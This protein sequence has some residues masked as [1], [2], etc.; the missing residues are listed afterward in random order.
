MLE[1]LDSILAHE[2][3]PKILVVGDVILDEYVTG[4]VGRISPEA[5]VPVLESTTVVKSPGGAANVAANLAALGCDVLLVG[6]VG[7]DAPGDALT[8]LL[9][10][11]GISTAGLVVDPSR[12]TTH[13]I[14]V[15]AQGQH[16][17]RID[18]EE[19]AKISAEAQ[20]LLINKLKVWI[21]ECDGV[22]CSDYE[23]GVLQPEVLQTLMKETSSRGRA[24]VVDP[25]GTGYERYVGAYALTPNVAEIETATGMKVTSV[26]SLDQAVALLFAQ[27]GAEVLLAT[28]GKDG[29]VVYEREGPKTAI[30]AEGREV[31]DVTGA[32]DTVVAVLAIGIFGGSSAVDAA[33]LANIAAG[34]VVGKL[35]TA[36]V[37]REELRRSLKGRAG[38]GQQKLI[39]REA[40]KEVAER[41]RARGQTVVFTNGCFD[42]LHAG[43]VQ[44]LQEARDE[45]DLLILGLNSDRSVRTL[46]GE[47]RPV[48]GE[49]DRA[50]ILGAMECVDHVVLFD[51]AT[52]QALVDA[53][54]PD[55]LVK[56]ADYKAEE[57]VGRETV[58]ANGGRLRLIRLVEGRSTSDIVERI[59]EISPCAPVTAAS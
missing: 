26:E 46:K 32:G 58:E 22:L 12:P 4:A 53:L 33:G 44:Y 14:R 8:G 18:R 49:G 16:V 36:T 1:Q 45:G 34:Q 40:A 3:R 21:P 48:M 31:Y 13:K 17:L 10:E 25:K 30:Q 23:K 6:V 41:A 54:V 35:G 11:R 9:Q 57:V 2:K 56:G 7:V 24:V 59:K 5:P 42:I 38:R 51:E 19:R 37:T 29:M 50:L 43:H 39:S 47:S 55:V 27:T 28:R 15:L 52:P 20:A